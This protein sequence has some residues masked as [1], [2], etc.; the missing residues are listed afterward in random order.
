MSSPRTAALIVAAGRGMRAGGGLPKQFRDLNGKPVLA[1]TLYVF[2]SHPLVDDILVVIH[3]DDEAYFKDHFDQDGLSYCFGGNTRS[4]SVR[5]GIEALASRP[6]ER[7]LIHDGA[8]PYLSTDLIDQLLLSLDTHSAVI[9]GLPQTD[10]TFEVA[11]DCLVAPVNRE[12]LVRAQTP[13]AFRFGVIREAF[14]HASEDAPAPDEASLALAHGVDV[15]VIPGD[16]GNSKLT[17][18]EDFQMPDN[19][20]AALTVSGQGF[21][22]HRLAEG[23]GVWLCGVFIACPLRLIGHSDADAGLHALT[24]ALLGAICAGDIGQHFP[25]SDPQWKD[26]PSSRFLAHAVELARRRGARPLHADVTLICERPKIGPHRD[27]M[28]QIIAE[29]M[30]LPT[31]RVNVKAT[32][33]EGLGYTGRGEGLAAQAIVTVQ[34]DE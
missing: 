17:F 19:S 13:Q 8:R 14:K 5:N 3:E 26:A 27:A 25:P 29:L 12:Q 23:E 30:G 16:P 24:D 1:H 33:T 20:T 7:I 21:D 2:R 11:E 6:I 10:A 28:K 31:A 4:K 32:T 22:V 34:I 18:A 15:A 9:P